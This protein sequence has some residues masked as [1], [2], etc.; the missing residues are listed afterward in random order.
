MKKKLIMGILAIVLSFSLVACG[1]KKD[2]VETGNDNEATTE[3]VEQTQG[4]DGSAEKEMIDA[5]AVATST[6]SK[7][8][9]E[10]FLAGK[11]EVYSDKTEIYGYYDYETDTSTDLFEK[12]KGYTLTDLIVTTMELD[13]YEYSCDT[14]NSLQYAY[15]DC[16][17]D[18]EPE[19]V[20]SIGT[21]NEYGEI[22]GSEYLI[23]NFDGK[24]EIC[25]KNSSY[26]RSYENF[27]NPYGLI[28]FG[29][30]MGAMSFGQGY[31]Y[32]NADGE[33]TYLYYCDTEFGLG[34][35][36][37]E[38]GGV[39]EVAA[40]Y[41]E[42]IDMDWCLNEYRF[43]ENSDFDFEN[44]DYSEFLKSAC[45]TVDPEG[46]ELIEKI[47]AE[48]NVKLYTQ[49]EMD[50]MIL[51]DALS[52]GVT[53]EI[54][55]STESVEWHDL[56]NDT[57][58]EL[59]TYGLNPI[60]VSTTEEFVD[61][62]ANGANI[63]LEPGIYNLTEYLLANE[64][65]LVNLNDYYEEKSENED[66]YVEGVVYSGNVEEPCFGI[67]NISN[68]KISSSDPKQMA[69]IVS[70][71]RY[72]DVMDFHSC[73]N[74][75]VNHVIMGHTP[76]QGGCSGDVIGI[77]NSVNVDVTGCDLYGCGAYGTYITDSSFVSFNDTKIHDCSYGCAEIYDG[78]TIDFDNCEFIDCKGSAMLFVYDSSVNFYGCSF[79]RLAEDMLSINE[80]TT[81]NFYDCTFDANA[82]SSLNNYNG[83]G[84][85]YVN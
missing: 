50:E 21:E 3:A 36:F 56:T 44:N 53:E 8:L 13:N 18:G 19:L 31:G 12:G 54:L 80:N 25:T 72:Q 82:L 40:K 74:I 59:K 51:A 68:L 66:A 24:L 39:Y 6:D 5:N 33:Y 11:G 29:G 41:E 71:P 70:E 63:F 27:E 37:G 10:D 58:E 22:S 42:D 45:Y 46:E 65:K 1:A 57:V 43:D 9:Y 81:M 16:G 73:Y 47:F 38:L 28:S 60:F 7:A 34:S 4:I 32:V 48:A 35:E 78:E 61:A 76:E 15:V 75:N 84:A 64:D 79:K 20:I 55:K 67:V 62:I 2:V 77:L 85:V 26:Y 69:E 17:K 30:S 83:A 14:I 49:K 52:K 23:K